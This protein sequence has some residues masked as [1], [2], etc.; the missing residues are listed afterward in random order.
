M[1]KI[2][3]T[4]NGPFKVSGPITVE[5]AEGNTKE[6]KEGEDAWLC[7]CGQSKNRPYC[8]GTHKKIGFKSN[9]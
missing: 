2:Q 8:D 7:R 1:V 9:K 3:A 6:F 5:D 4:K